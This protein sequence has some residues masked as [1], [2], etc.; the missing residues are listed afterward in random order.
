MFCSSFSTYAVSRKEQ[1]HLLQLNIQNC[2]IHIYV[3]IYSL[4]EKKKRKKEYKKCIFVE[5]PEA[6]K[7]KLTIH[8]YYYLS[9]FSLCRL[10][11]CLIMHGFMPQPILFSDRDKKKKKKVDLISGP[12]NPIYTTMLDFIS[13]FL[14]KRKQKDLISFHFLGGASKFYLH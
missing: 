6:N 5:T 14:K 12:C 2:K 7:G 11:F 3:Y 13:F 9:P 10:G 4:G 1:V 8:T